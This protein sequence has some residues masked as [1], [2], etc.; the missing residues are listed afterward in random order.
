MRNYLFGFSISL[1]FSRIFFG[2]FVGGGI[3]FIYAVNRRQETVNRIGLINRSIIS[4][5][6]KLLITLERIRISGKSV[7]MRINI[8]RMTLFSVLIIS[9]YINNI[10]FQVVSLVQQ[11]QI[12]VGI[13][14]G[15]GLSWIRQER[16]I[17]IVSNVV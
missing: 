17:N 8:G 12:I 14:I 7:F 16:I 15:N 1:S 4:K 5:V 11:S 3:F 10:V 9:F 6:I 2:W 13:S